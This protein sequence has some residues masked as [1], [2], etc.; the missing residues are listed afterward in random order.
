MRASRILPFC[1]A[2]AFLLTAQISFGQVGQLGGATGGTT[3]GGGGAT[4]GGG[5]GGGG[6][7]AGAT[8]GGTTQGTGG[9]T[10]QGIGAGGADGGVAGGN[11]AEFFVGGNNAEGFVGAGLTTQRNNNRQFQIITEPSLTTGGTREVNGTPRRIPT[12]LR[13]AF[14]HPEANASS[15]LVGPQGSALR[16]VA[17]SK[18]ELRQVSVQLGSDGIAVLTGVAPDAGSRRLAANLVRLRPGVRK[19]DNQIAVADQ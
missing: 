7:G 15:L 14:S 18:P 8:A 3:G 16:Q 19:V 9:L 1:T 13:V 2:A 11:L 12:S 4:A 5:T 6:A 10:T 17:N